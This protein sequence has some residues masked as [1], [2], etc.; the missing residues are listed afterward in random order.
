MKNKMLT[1]SVFAFSAIFAA[2]SWAVDV[3]PVDSGDVVT[4]GRWTKN[5]DAAKEMADKQHIPLFIFWGHPSCGYCDTC[6]SEGFNSAVFKD[7]QAK[8]KIIMVY[9]HPSSYASTPGKEFAKEGDTTGGELPYCR[10][11]WLKPDGKISNRQFIGRRTRLPVQDAGSFPENII[12]SIEKYIKDY[13]GTATYAGGKF[14]DANETY[15][16][17]EVEDGTTNLIVRLSR[18]SA[19]KDTATNSTII[20]YKKDGKT[21]LATKKVTWAKGKTSVTASVPVK[22]ANAGLTADGQKLKLILA[23]GGGKG[24]YST[25]YVTYVKAA[26]SSSNPLWI[27]ERAK[28]ELKWGEWTMDLDVAKAKV[29]GATGDAWTLVSVQGSL[30]C[31]DCANTD[32]NFLDIKE[33]STDTQTKFQKWAAGNQI[34]LVTIDIPRFNGTTKTTWAKTEDKV[35]TLLSRTAMETTLA[36]EGEYPASGADKDLLKPYPR[37]GLGYLTRKCVTDAE[38]DKLLERNWKLTSNDVLA[39]PKG[40]HLGTDGRPNRMAVPAFILLRKDGTVASRFTYF[41]STASPMKADQAKYDDY[42]KRFEEMLKIAGDKDGKGTYADKTEPANNYPAKAA[43]VALAAAKGEKSAYLSHTDAVDTYRL[44]GVRGGVKQTVEFSGSCADGFYAQFFTLDKNGKKVAQ[45]GDKKATLK[46]GLKLSRT[47]TD[48]ATDIYVEF[49]PTNA[50]VGAFAPASTKADNFTKYTVRTSLVLDPQESRRTYTGTAGEEIEVALTKGQY[51]GF[52]GLDVSSIEG[53]LEKVAESSDGIVVYTA[54]VDGDVPLKLAKAATTYTKAGEL[55][56]QKWVPGRV[57]FKSASAKVAEKDKNF[58]VNVPIVREN[59][60]SGEISV[61]VSLNTEKTTLYTKDGKRRFLMPGGKDVQ[62]LTLGD[63]WTGTTNFVLTIAGD[64][65]YDGNGQVVLDL[66]LTGGNAESGTSRYTLTVTEND[67]PTPG[68]A[69]FVDEGG[70]WPKDYAVY[71]QTTAGAVL[72]VARRTG[73]DSA[74]SVKLKTTAGKLSATTLKW[75]DFDSAVKEVRLTGLAAGKSATVT[76]IEPSKGFEVDKKAKSVKVTSVP[77]K[78]PEFAVTRASVDVFRYVDAKV[79]FA[80]KNYKGGKLAFTKVSGSG[81]LPGGLKVSADQ[82][83]PGAIVFTG[84]PT[85]VGDYEVAYQV[86][87]TVSG[88]KVNGLTARFAFHV[89]DQTDAASMKKYDGKANTS[90]V[91]SRTIKDIMI[92]DEAAG[93][94]LGTLQLTIPRTGK[95]SGKYASRNGTVSLS[96]KA[97]SSGSNPV[98]GSLNAKL[99]NSK[100]YALDLTV[101]ANGKLKMALTDPNEKKLR[102][103]GESNGKVWGKNKYYATAWKGYYTVTL[104]VA[105]IISEGCEGLAPTGNGYLTLKMNTSSAWNAGKVTW[106]GML[107]NGTTLSG[108]AVL[109]ENGSVACLPVFKKMSKDVF[110]SIVQINKNALADKA[111]NRRAVFNAE[112]FST[113]W[114]HTESATKDACY[115]LKLGVYGGIFDKDEKMDSCC[116]EFELTNVLWLKPSVDEYL[117][118]DKYGVPGE[119]KPVQFKV[120]GQKMSLV[121]KASEN[122]QKITLSF[123]KSTGVVSGSFKIPYTKPDGEPTTVSATYKGVVLTGWG[124][125]CGCGDV[126]PETVFLPFV[127]GAFYFTDALNYTAS[128]R[129]KTLSVKRGGPVESSKAK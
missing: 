61:K 42:I 6:I 67:T 60:S 75:G 39:D 24:S 20:V 54:A 101:A 8:R 7:W 114:D 35:P 129:N 36:R 9:L 107:A 90:V 44:T 125:G 17:L 4:P 85:K 88:K 104:P 124:E 76:L 37:S 122:P 56:Y 19:V 91:T 23:D 86:A 53:K 31:P 5:F 109:T 13:T 120:E 82:S 118:S 113:F 34:A 121:T 84:I 127:N 79:E 94:L 1:W 27:G 70:N 57:G 72:Y 43:S 26:N 47:F 38:A 16:R 102:L 97:W 10:I 50:E 92:Y 117:S 18:E 110:S 28:D 55:I 98:T 66:A 14:A 15:N 32:R 116:K 63:G 108:S 89:Y 106:A 3:S 111:K 95:V 115:S 12:A 41:G 119:V 59:G 46:S 112:G 33:K 87:E 69:A 83:K 51:Y 105:E 126:S 62:E 49:G 77:D 128:K 99:T 74:V 21:K 71:A 93:R 45:G 40:F 64:S 29:K 123:A 25:N 22:I 58:N 11:Y 78:G 65:H 52:V 2:M 30:W 103:V 68:E 100:G 80:L 48:T 81:S 73:S 96:A